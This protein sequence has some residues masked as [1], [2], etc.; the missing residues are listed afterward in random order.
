MLHSC[1]RL[2]LGCDLLDVIQQCGVI[3]AVATLVTHTDRHVFQDDET[4]SVLK[5]FPCYDSLL[6]RAIA[7]RDWGTID[8]K[9][10]KGYKGSG[11]G[12]DKGGDYTGHDNFPEWYFRRSEGDKT[13]AKPLDRD[14]YENAKVDFYELCRWDKNTGVPTRDTLESHDLK[15][16]ADQLE[17]INLLPA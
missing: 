5:C 17:K 10:G 1:R 3:V 8:L 16:V 14:D 15:D 4:V 2:F 11:R 9:G 12:R 7:V 13:T 6:H